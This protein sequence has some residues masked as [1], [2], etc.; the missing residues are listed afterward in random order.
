MLTPQALLRKKVFLATLS[1][2]K[3]VDAPVG[4]HRQERC[5]LQGQ[6]PLQVL[7]SCGHHGEPQ[8]EEGARRGKRKVVLQMIE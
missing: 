7:D 1:V 3:G 5:G 6:E 8:E 2:I 4:P